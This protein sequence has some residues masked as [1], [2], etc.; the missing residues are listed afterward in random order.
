MS[1][2]AFLSLQRCKRGEAPRA[3][4]REERARAFY[5]MRPVPQGNNYRWQHLQAAEYAKAETQDGRYH[6]TEF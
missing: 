6:T 2:L 5:A 3:P 1:T 4:T